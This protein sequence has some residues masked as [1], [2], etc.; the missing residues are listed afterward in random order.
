LWVKKFQVFAG[1]SDKKFQKFQKNLLS[2]LG[3]I[4]LDAKFQ[5]KMYLSEWIKKQNSIPKNT[6]RIQKLEN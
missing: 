1:V 2:L 4:H 6:A 5:K 3:A